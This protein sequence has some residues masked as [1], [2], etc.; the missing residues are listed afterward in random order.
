MRA[1]PARN[2]FNLLHSMLLRC[3][4]IRKYNIALS[5][6]FKK[7]RP[8]DMAKI[9]TTAIVADIRNK[10]NGS[11]F[12]K[13]RYGSYVRT[14]V[15]PVNPQ[16]TAQMAVRSN[17]SALSASWR[18]LTEAQR[19]GWIDSAVNF[20][21][22]D[23]FGNSKIL[24]GNALYVGLNTNLISVGASGIDDAPAPQGFPPLTIDIV[25]ATA[26]TQALSISFSPTPVDANFAILL[27][28]TGNV[29]PGKSFVKNLYRVIATIP[30]AGSSP[31]N[32]LADFTAVH[33]ALVEGQKIFV[34]ASLVSLLSGQKGLPSQAETIVT[35]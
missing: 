8:K 20:P 33:G 10:L 21:T 30:S 14:K 12:S 24:S 13:N 28:A 17:L 9:L 15:T 2:Y 27:Q 32:A 31:F 4:I 16:S 6:A 25:T 34:R 35:L 29:G 5:C 18:A 23:I 19:K 3:C 22:T 7:P 1:E 26:G 11:V